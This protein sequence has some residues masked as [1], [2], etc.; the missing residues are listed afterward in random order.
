MTTM[1]DLRLALPIRDVR[2]RTGSWG[3]CAGV[4]VVHA[5]LEPGEKFELVSPLTAWPDWGA[6][7]WDIA[8]MVAENLEIGMRE[9]FRALLDAEPP[10]RVV[11][12]KVTNQPVN[13]NE[14]GSR[15][16]GRLLV[17]EAVRAI[18]R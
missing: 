1:A 2:I 11:L 12:R 8:E 7:L 17:E 6:E 9:A 13:F 4:T 5:D 16:V 14:M 3:N 18:V 15:R 10:V